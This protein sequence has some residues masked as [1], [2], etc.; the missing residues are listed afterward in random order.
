MRA[1]VDHL[2]AANPALFVIDVS[3]EIA[4]L[5]RIASVPAI[6][7]RMHGDRLDPGH[8][9]AYQA[10]VGLLAPFGAA[11]EQ[12]DTPDWVRAKT[13][14]AGGLCT[15]GDAIDPPKPT[16]ARRWASTPSR[17]SSWS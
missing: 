6:S 4:L 9:G 8:L 11:L 2:D 3:A 13:C 1:I 12:P 5:A 10:S 16:P 14:Y 15:T 17:R 7:M